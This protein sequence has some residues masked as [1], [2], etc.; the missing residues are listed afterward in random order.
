MMGLIYFII[1]LG[2]IVIVHEFGHFIIGKVSGVTVEEFAIGMG[3]KL[4]GFNKNG[5]DYSLRLFPIGGYCKFKDEDGLQSENGEI[6]D[7]SFNSVSVWKRIS[8][9]TAG[10]IFNMVL[11]YVLC[12]IICSGSGVVLPV[13]NEI[14]DGYPAQEAGFQSGDKIIKINGK[15]IYTTSDMNLVTMLSPG[16]PLEIVYGR[17]GEQFSVEVTPKKDENGSY[18]IGFGNFGQYEHSKGLR[19]F[20]HAYYNARYYFNIV[21][22]SLRMLFGGQVTLDDMAGPVGMAQ[23][24]SDIESE[25]RQVYDI[26]TVMMVMVSLTAMLSVNIGI[27]N[28]LPIPALDGGRLV[29]LLIEAVRGKPIPVKYEAAIDGVFMLLL[30]GFM[31]V[32]SFN[33]VLRIFNI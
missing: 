32:V 2:I 7:G 15:R 22:E 24:V 23:M 26:K 21:F 9:V 30:F 27:M 17:N 10:P 20:K 14:M 25:A 31:I 3:P 11:T 13:V 29:F 6:T 1:I 4:I 8:I 5:T 33:D 19:V 28:L 16:E 12:I 18:L